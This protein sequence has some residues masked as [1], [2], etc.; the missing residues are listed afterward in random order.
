MT[1]HTK[2][3]PHVLRRVMELMQAPEWAVL[4]AVYPVIEPAIKEIKT[5]V[6][7]NI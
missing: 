5:G 2:L 4:S 3:G 1:P 7:V 6:V